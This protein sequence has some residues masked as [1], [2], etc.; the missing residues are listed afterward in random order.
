M[1]PVRSAEEV[2]AALNARTQRALDREM[3]P[4]RREMEARLAT[5]RGALAEE[6]RREMQ[7][8]AR[9][10]ERERRD[11]AL[12]EV[13]LRSQ[14]DVLQGDLK[15]ETSRALERLL[16]ERA[17]SGSRRLAEETALRSRLAQRW[18]DA[19]E[20]IEGEVERAVATAAARAAH[21]NRLVVEEYRRSVRA[22]AGR[23]PERAPELRTPMPAVPRAASGP[24]P[25]PEP[26]SSVAGPWR[27]PDPLGDARAA[28]V[29]AIDEDVMSAVRRIV[30]TKRWRLAASPGP[31]TPDE[32]ETVAKLLREA[33]PAWR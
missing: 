9:R 23:V 24:V 31:R 12:R 18:V 21:E 28:L 33:W 15:E 30:R 32:T 2:A 25:M 8:I 11:S 19:R 14:I 29:D 1:R 10:Y 27:S 4:L 7:S 13:A 6:E 26:G 5:V 16:R 20:A 17:E 22:G 3:V